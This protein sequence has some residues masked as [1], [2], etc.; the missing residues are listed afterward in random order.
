MNK[1]MF[2]DTNNKIISSQYTSYDINNDDLFNIIYDPYITEHYHFNSCFLN[3]IID[4]YRKAFE[5]K[6]KKGI[7]YYSE[8]T[9][10]SLCKI[11]EIKHQNNDIGL[12]INKSLAFFKKL[13]LGLVVLLV[14]GNIIFQYKPDNLEIRPLSKYFVKSNLDISQNFYECSLFEA[15]ITKKYGFLLLEAQKN[16]LSFEIFYQKHPSHLVNCDFKS[17]IDELY[18]KSDLEMKY[19]KNCA[20]IIIGY[21]EKTQNKKFITKLFNTLDEVSIYAIQY[22]GKVKRFSESSLNIDNFPLYVIKRTNYIQQ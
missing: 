6:D 17:I 7:R 11:L 5:K 13:K 3:I 1:M 10:E 8:L 12:T 16:L 20:N 15:T 4:T 14:F 21:M 22:N 2:D 9:Y 19:K 18:N